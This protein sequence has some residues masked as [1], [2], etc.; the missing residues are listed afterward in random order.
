M[1]RVVKPALDVAIPLLVIV[2]CWCFGAA[3]VVPFYLVLIALAVAVIWRGYYSYTDA[4]DAVQLDCGF[5]DTVFGRPEPVHA[6]LTVIDGGKRA[7]WPN[8]AGA[9]E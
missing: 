7:V 2:A 8:D 1:Q 6:P 9:V 3:F 5:G 4:R